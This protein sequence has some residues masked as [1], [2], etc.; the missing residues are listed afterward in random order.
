M[1]ICL[2]GGRREKWVSTHSRNSREK[3][4]ERKSNEDRALGM[5]LYRIKLCKSW[6]DSKWK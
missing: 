3:K 1:F 6:R 5:L 4:M 2:T